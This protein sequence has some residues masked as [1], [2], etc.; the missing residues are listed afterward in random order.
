MLA[1]QNEQHF[2][3]NSINKI[4]RSNLKGSI[5]VTNSLLTSRMILESTFAHGLPVK[6][7]IKVFKGLKRSRDV[8]KSFLTSRAILE[9]NIL[10]SFPE[11]PK[12]ND[13]KET[14][15]L[16][17]QQSSSRCCPKAKRRKVFY[18]DMESE[19]DE[20]RRKMLSLL[21]KRFRLVMPSN[22]LNGSAVNSSLVTTVEQL[23]FKTASSLDVYSDEATLD[24]RMKR[25]MKA[26]FRRRLNNRIK[27]ELTA[28]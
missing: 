9:S 10:G 27:S 21:E 17:Q 19:K 25:L 6:A 14:N 16:I 23:L 13:E 24:F 2:S 12:C 15:S 22:K 8:P 4:N 11:E 20:A 7:N 3:I 28:V 18:D 1:P 5:K 26:L